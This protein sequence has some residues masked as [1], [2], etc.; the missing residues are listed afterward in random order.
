MTGLTEKAGVQNRRLAG[1]AR[2]F[3]GDERGAT[4][5]EYG[6]IVALIFLA[7]VSAIRGYTDSTGDM[8]STIA[9]AME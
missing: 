9:D 1:A 8:Y 2:K 4:A 7:V 5:I 3:A 6:L